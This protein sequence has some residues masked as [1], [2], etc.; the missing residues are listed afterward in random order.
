MTDDRELVV[1]ALRRLAAAARKGQPADAHP[2]V[3]EII[4]YHAGEL[5]AERHQ[6]LQQ[7][8]L[9]CRDCPDLILAL[10]GFA[11]LPEGEVEAAPAGM[12]SAWEAVRHQLATEGWFAGGRGKVVRPWR[13]L[14][15][16]RTLL[17]AAALVVVASLGFFL[18][19]N[20][21]PLHIVEQPPPGSPQWEL[22]P[23]VRGG[24]P[25]RTIGNP[26]SAGGFT[27]AVSPEGRWSSPEYQVELLG[28]EGRR[29]WNDP[30]RPRSPST[31]FY[32]EVPRGSLPAGEY[33]LRLAGRGAAPE[34]PDERRFRLDFR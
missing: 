25:V 9:L 17:A 4:A 30:W 23:A 26:G 13:T 5:T 3:E 19:R 24:E 11:K 34:P 16:P 8:L 15:P 2:T 28:P 7:H 22:A 12:D 21:R 18:L 27:L 33:L 10:D 32:L 14:L 29:L 6:A 31:P 20:D 1:H